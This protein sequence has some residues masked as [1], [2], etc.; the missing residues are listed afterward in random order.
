MD[1]VAAT[2]SPPPKK[3]DV[4]RWSS[5]LLASRLKIGSATIARSWREYGVQPWKSETFTL[6]TDPEL[7]GEVTDVVG[8]YLAPPESA[9]ILCV[10]EKSQIQGLDRTAPMLP[11]RIGDTENRTHD[12]KRHG[13]TTLFAALE[14]AT[15]HVTGAV[16]PKH[17]RQEFSH[18]FANSTALTLALSCTS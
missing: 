17:R 6:S 2:L 5:R 4:T 8:L 18:S 13:T 11:M 10:N 14:I 1:I 15:G 9:I 7:V 16:K 3:C 12:D